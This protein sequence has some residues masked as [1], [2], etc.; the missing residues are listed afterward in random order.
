[1][2]PLLLKRTTFTFFQFVVLFLLLSITSFSQTTIFTYA[3]AW[4]YSNGA[5]AP[6]NDAQADT[7]IESDYDD[8]AWSS[9]TAP[10]Q[11]GE[12]I[13][14]STNL[15]TLRNTTYFRKSFTVTG[16]ASYSDFDLNVVRDD[17]AVIYINGVQV[18]ITN[19]PGGPYLFS[20]NASGQVN[21]G[22]EPNINPINI[23]SSYFTE[24]T[25]VIAVEVHQAST[26][27]SDM[28]FSLELLANLAPALSLS[29]G[30]YLQ[31]GS[32]TAL[33]FRWRTNIASDSRV[34]V[35]TSFGSYTVVTDD[36][37]STTEHTVRVTGLSADTKYWYRIGSTSQ[38]LQ[39]A[40]D[41]FFTT[42]PSSTPGRKLRFIA[43]GDCGRGNTTYQDQ[44]L[45]QYTSYLT[46]NGID[47][48]DAW[49]LLGDNAYNAGTDAEYTT[50]FFG[51]YGGSIL[52]N[53]K[54][55]PVPG[56]HDYA[57]STTN[58]DVHSN[59]PYYSI[60]NLPSAGEAGGVASNKEEYYS[61][62]V[63]NVHFLALDAYGEESNKRIYDTTGAQALWI[64]SDLA[65]NAFTGKW[66]VAYWHHPPYTMGSHN[67]DSETELISM[68]ENFIR[69]LE[70]YGVDM[71]INGHSHD[72]ERSLLMKGYYKVNA[73]DPQVNE[74]NFN[75][76][77]NVSSS[78]AT[79]SSNLTCPY[80]TSSTASNKG[81]VYV[82]AGSTGASGSTQT[83]YPHN[84]LPQSI[85]DGGVFYFEVDGNR[86]DAKFIERTGTIWDQF[87]IMRDVNKTT[88]YTIVNGSSKNLSA[89]WPGNF[90]WST[91]ANTQSISVTPPNNAT[92]N[93]SVTD[94]FG[95]VT[96]NFSITTT[97]SLPVSLLSYD[98]K[99]EAD[100]VNVT[101][102]TSSEVNTNEFII[103]KSPLPSGNFQ[104][105]G[106][107]KAAGESSTVLKYLFTDPE[108]LPGISYY[109]LSQTD[110]DGQIR[111][112]DVKKINNTKA[113]LFAVS[114]VANDNG[115]LILQI[116]TA[117]QE[118]VQ[119][120]IFDITGKEIIKNNIIVS[121][122]TNLRTI[123]LKS[124][125]YVWEVKNNH[126][127]RATQ[128]TIVK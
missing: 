30:P 45:T 84:A 44:S 53:H 50:N 128:V 68:R 108:P 90:N 42:L 119:I 51:I 58:Q 89:S 21:S 73:A 29:R 96:D 38:S 107:V 57:N 55:Y 113:K 104:L 100:K 79:Y 17:G 105:V 97:V 26:N 32:Q 47:A 20:T 64:K 36:A 98:A 117:Q 1:M 37:V 61:Y 22:S 52:K 111:Y 101:W 77:Y 18:G 118:N 92:T 109:R 126:G 10:F 28:R 63:G 74:V 116:K 56:N 85:N 4:K 93:Y 40:T 110:I 39:G 103:E 114:Q 69:I 127:E 62:D 122:G 54:L 23:S 124:G 102:S 43:F 35:G 76:S 41:N 16:L 34:E 82:V 65:A 14:G 49:L 59:C 115:M 88:N 11:V 83:G 94:A 120:R 112:Y 67:S 12:T 78:L 95:C 3:S 6:A 80:M 13:T 7:W 87:T 31:S 70:R 81:T 121:A 60:F 123:A 5:A 91:S 125:S 48:P 75:S 66:I 27:G 2:T 72:Y 8:A 24:G 99:L 33:T 86:L 19:M 9:A 46:A 25:N 15:G 106:K 71:I